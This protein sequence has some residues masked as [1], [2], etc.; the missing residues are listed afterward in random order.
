M[1]PAYQRCFNCSIDLYNGPEFIAIL[2]FLSVDGRNE[3]S[4]QLSDDATYVVSV[5]PS[6]Y[7]TD[8]H[9]LAYALKNASDLLRLLKHC[10]NQ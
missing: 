3:V 8:I 9:P 1:K 5:A 6:G 4:V 10:Y 2:H 7:Q